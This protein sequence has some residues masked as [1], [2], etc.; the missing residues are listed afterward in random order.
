MLDFLQK[1]LRQFGPSGSVVV[2]GLQPSAPW[3]VDD[4]DTLVPYE[5]SAVTPEQF[6][7][8]MEEYGKLGSANY[9][10]IE[11]RWPAVIPDVDRS[12]YPDLKA[13]CDDV[14]WTT[15]RWAEDVRCGRIAEDGKVLDRMTAAK[16]PFLTPR[17]RSEIW[18]Y[19]WFVAR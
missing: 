16:Y 5:L 10:P 9:V 11:Q 19:A 13:Q 18:T 12:K 17:R 7:R 4:P 2:P 6:D 1:V 3:V 8:A 14:R 15:A